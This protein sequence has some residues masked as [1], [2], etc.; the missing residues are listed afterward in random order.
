[1]NTDP[2]EP[3]TPDTDK[4]TTDL[5]TTDLAAAPV[6]SSGFIITL[7]VLT[8]GL[9]AG[10]FLWTNTRLNTLEQTLETLPQ[11]TVDAII[12][13]QNGDTQSQPP[14]AG[15]PISVD[16]DAVLGSPDAQLVMVE[17][18]DFNCGFCGRYHA[19]TFPQ[20]LSTYIESGDLLYVYRDYIGVGGQVSLAAANAAECVRAQTGDAE[21]ME[22][23]QGMFA[24]SGR[25]NVDRVRSLASGF[26]LDEAALEACIANE[27]FRDE[28]LADTST[29]QG[30]GARGTPAFFIG[31]LNEDGTVEGINIPGAQPFSVFEQVIAERLEQ[32]N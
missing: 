15:G 32:L 3:V 17:F 4:S 26:D 5:P 7:L 2:Q 25:K 10:L 22:I 8:I 18:S 31:Q 16:D 24:G 27:E 13:L 11:S 30:A 14:P 21:Y 1:M 9:L 20:L 23:V 28:V 6:R 12:A 29:A 19:E